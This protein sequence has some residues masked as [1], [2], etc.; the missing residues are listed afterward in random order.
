MKVAYI[1]T[2][3][4]RECG[5]ATF[6]HNLMRAINAN[7]PGRKSLKQGGFVVAL[8]DS[9]NM[10]EYDYPEE[11]QYIIRQNQQ[12]DYVCAAN[13][14][15]QAMRIFAYLSTSLAFTAAITAFI[16]FHCL[17]GWRNRLSQFYIPY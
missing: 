5:I 1:S 11:V 13:F 12:K 14:I 2:Y 4:P 8:N 10:E 15:T 17:T 6:N 7:F 3:L 16:Y 9:E